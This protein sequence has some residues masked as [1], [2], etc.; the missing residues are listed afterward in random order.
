[1]NWKYFG[2]PWEKCRE[3]WASYERGI[4][5]ENSLRCYK[6]GIPV[7]ALKVGL[8]EFIRLLEEKG[9]TGKY[10]VFP[11]PI[12]LASKG[13]I[14]L[15]FESREEMEKAINE[16][17]KHIVNEPKDQFFFD[18]F[19]NVDWINGFNYRRGCPEYDKVFGDWRKWKIQIDW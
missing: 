2:R 1:M 18:T 13:V 16:L 19:V 14:L 5:H 11:F 3:C 12:S 10:A 7:R 8:E 17:S 9:Y 6:L 4:Q 15:Y